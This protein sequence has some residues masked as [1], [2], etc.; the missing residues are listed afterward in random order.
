MNPTVATAAVTLAAAALTF[1]VAGAAHAD[2]YVTTDP[3]D[4][5]HG[6]DVLGVKVRN[7]DKVVVTTDHAN[8]RRPPSSGSSESIYIDTDRHDAG[9]EYVFA[10]GLFEGTDYVLLETEGFATSKWGDPVS[11]GS[12]RMSVDYAADRVRFVISRASLDNPGAIRVSVRAGGTR[13]DGTNVVD[14]VGEPRSF[15]PWIARG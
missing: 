1:G 15:S 3:R 6:V 7:A 8:L 11:R 13:A 10:A 2:S 9:P 14:W 4:T 5:A 12:Y